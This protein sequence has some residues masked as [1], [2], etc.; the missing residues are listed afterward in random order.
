MAKRSIEVDGKVQQLDPKFDPDDW[1][2]EMISGDPTTKMHVAKMRSSMDITMNDKQ[3]EETVDALKRNPPELFERFM[4]IEAQ[5][6]GL[7]YTPD[8]N[9][10]IGENGSPVDAG[11]ERR[12][13]KQVEK[14]MV[15][16]NPQLSEFPEFARKAIL[17]RV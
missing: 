16:R 4:Q 5:N 15:I 8:T 6:L 10:L 12:L 14:L 11:T 9:Q 3:M 17:E 7:T 13:R 1:Q 2:K